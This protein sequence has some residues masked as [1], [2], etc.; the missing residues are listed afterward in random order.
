MQDIDRRFV[1]LRPDFYV[2]ATAA[3]ADELGACLDQF[4]GALQLG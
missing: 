1:V 3:S 4:L 2:A